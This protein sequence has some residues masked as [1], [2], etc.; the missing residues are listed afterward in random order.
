MIDFWCKT[1]RKQKFNSVK[2]LYNRLEKFFIYNNYCEEIEQIYRYGLVDNSHVFRESIHD[3]SCIKN[4]FNLN[5]NIW[6]K[7]FM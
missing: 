6:K 2:L 1:L 3:P 4:N 7:K 5:N